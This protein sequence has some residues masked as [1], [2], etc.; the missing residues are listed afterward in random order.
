MNER[1]RVTL[2]VLNPRGV[3]KTVPVTGLSSPR[4]ADLDGKR[5]ALLSEKQ[6]S[7]QFFD[8]IEALLK[9][10]YP[11]AT[12]AR[13]DSPGN[14]MQPD[15]TA[16][17]AAE[18]DTWLEGVKTSGSSVIDYCVKLEKLGKPGAP[19]S[20]EGLLTQRRRLAEVNGMPT[21]R[22]VTVP[23]LDF[24][25]AEGYPDR[26]EAV[27]A[28]VFDSIVQTLT[29]PLTEEEK[30]PN[31]H[32]YDYGPLGFSGTSHDEVLE[33]FQEYV[34]NNHLGDGLPVTPPTLEAVAR[35]LTGTSR[36]PQE[37]IGPLAPRNGLATIEKIAINAV[38]AGAKPEYLPVIIAAIECVADPA[39]N[40][41]HLSTSTGSP[42]PIVWVNGPIAEEIGMNGG[43]GFLG[44]GNRANGTIGR[45]V[46]LCLINIG[47][48]L[49]DA[50]PGHI[51]DP[52]G[53]CNFTFPENERQNPWES[54][55]VSCGY[56]PEDSTVTVNETMSYN[57]Q[58]PGGGMT[59][60]TME[61]S[62]ETIAGMI[63]GSGSPMTKLMFAGA[64]RYQLV[65]NPT[66]ARQLAD[67]GF[68]KSSV[69]EWLQKKTSTTW[70]EL[71]LGE[72][73]MVKAFSSSP[74]VPWMKPEDC[75][76]GMII[77]SFADP[78]QLAVL[79]AGDPGGN[80][81]LW[82]SPVGSTTVSPDI[83]STVQGVPP[84]FMTKRIHGAALTKAGR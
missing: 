61:Q 74:M 5:I 79:V 82:T 45:A 18:C 22:V 29:A 3:L 14:P 58:G 78:E 59:S 36:H 31:P 1:S 12:I 7:I 30:N 20:V 77:P 38:M 10:R 83:A 51:G 11:T 54:F 55:A 33:A 75:G 23:T 65:L 66:L 40:L 4:A 6:S 9:E 27:A 16:E 57:R 81:V 47:W 52:E 49:M 43:M 64:C 73:E 17:V 25:G 71:S 68:R 53:F 50:D 41:Y 28:A 35:M 46:G 26:M 63:K 15:N 44:R 21:L 19:V 76:P 2:E 24:M 48:R 32:S 42:T 67:A 37:E 8:A 69:A 34:V 80:T 62:L 70:E 56:A 39:F 84:L 60:L 72:Q 13:F